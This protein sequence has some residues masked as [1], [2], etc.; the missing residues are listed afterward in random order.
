MISIGEIC[1]AGYGHN[2]HGLV[3]TFHRVQSIRSKKR[4]RRRFLAIA[5]AAF[6]NQQA[7]DKLYVHVGRFVYL[8]I[9]V[10]VCL[11]TGN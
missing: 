11:P 5:S 1:K 7:D 9:G 4:A 3:K 6:S 8:S 2:K 10:C